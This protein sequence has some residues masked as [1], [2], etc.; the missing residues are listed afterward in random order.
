M[1][2]NRNE[3]T[4]WLSQ[5]SETGN[6]GLRLGDVVYLW[7]NGPKGLVARGE[8]AQVAKT[9]VGMPLWQQAFC[10][11]EK[12]GSMGPQFH[13]TMPRPEIKI[14]KQIAAGQT[15]NRD[16]TDNNQIL[17]QNPFLRKGGFY[18]RTIF[19]LTE[20]QAHELA[21]LACWPHLP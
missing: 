12:T 1:K 10:V 16:L 19:D 3:D 13:K 20:P 15:V 14:T 11:D 8:V 18:L 17:K 2:R 7:E 5:K 9:D 6:E 21:N 4:L